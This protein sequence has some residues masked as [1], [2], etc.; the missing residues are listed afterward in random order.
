[1]ATYFSQQ[2]EK[3]SE[4][5]RSQSW[6]QQAESSFQQLPP[7]QQN[8]IK[9]GSIA[10]LLGSLIYFSWTLISGAHTM[11]RNYFAE[12]ELLQIVN[13][14]GEELRRLRGQNSGFSG[15]NN[16]SYKEIFAGLITAQ[17]L[18]VDRAEVLKESPGTGQGNLQETLVDVNIK[19]IAIRPLVQLLFQV[20]H[21]NPPMKI[22]QLEIQNEK[23]EGVMNVKLAVSGFAPKKETKK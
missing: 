3:V 1:M 23:A 19:E 21:G 18:P 10:T 22:R 13:Q 4:S 17:G 12:Q 14:A 2:W 9:Q 7:N 8:W 5:I 11:K 6:Y 15:A 16:Q 20:E